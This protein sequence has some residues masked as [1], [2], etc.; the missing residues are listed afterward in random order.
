MIKENLIESTSSLKDNEQIDSIKTETENKIEQNVSNTNEEENNIITEN[1]QDLNQNET[2]NIEE[3]IDEQE[4]TS[5]TNIFKIIG[6]IILTFSI[7]ILIIFAAFSIYTYKNKNVIAKGIYINN[8]D[9]SN[10]TPSDAKSKLEN[11]YSEKLSNDINLVYNDYSTYIKPSEIDLSFDINSAVEYAYNLGKNNNIFVSNYEIFK[12]M[13]NG[14]EI[15][16]TFSLNEE[17]LINYLNTFSSELPDAVKESEY[18]IEGKNLIITPGS[19]GISID[20]ASTTNNI[21]QKIQNLSYIN[22]PINMTT[23]L[24]NP[25]PINIEDIYNNV[26]SEA[27]DAYYTESPF[28]VYPSANGIDFAIS[29]D[30]AKELVSSEASE[31]TIPLKIL[32]P[33][34]TTNMIGQEAFPDLLATFSTKYAASNADRTTNLRIASNKINGYVLLPGDTFSYNATL[35]PRTASA[36]YKEAAVYEN[37]EVVQG[38]GGGICQISTTLY[39]AILFANLEIVELYNHQFVPSYVSAGRD[40]TVVYGIKDFK[41]KN[42]RKYPIKITCS[43]SNGTASFKIWGHKEETEYDVNVYANITG[44]TSSYIKSATYRTLKLNGQTIK[45]EHIAN[46][47]YKVH[48]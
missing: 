1:E 11:Y 16:P 43:V 3:N 4:Y 19:S 40:A 5:K 48:E 46:S 13:I 30:E 42:S 47:T 8:V 34:V 23:T 45:T 22:N 6:L 24:E 12:T 18:Y 29:L 21:K 9:I 39:N 7:I 38:I 10:L 35:G 17:N 25:K 44:K 41:F 31:I 27:K 15:T 20:I 26:H 32:Y 36:G 37:G 33:K 2:I 14:V 28:T